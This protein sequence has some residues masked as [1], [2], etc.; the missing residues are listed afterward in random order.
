MPRKKYITMVCEI[1]KDQTWNSKFYERWTLRSRGAKFVTFK[2]QSTPICITVVVKATYYVSFTS[3]LACFKSLSMYIDSDLVFGIT[4]SLLAENVVLIVS[5][6]YKICKSHSISIR[7]KDYSTINIYGCI[8]KHL[9]FYLNW[10]HV[11]KNTE[12]KQRLSFS[13]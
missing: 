13:Q 4:C 6:V 1:I 9:I 10:C 3:F 8:S 7:A 2:I 5:V 11:L 12:L